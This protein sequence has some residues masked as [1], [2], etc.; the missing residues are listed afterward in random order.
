MT[1]EPVVPL[2]PQIS[3]EESFLSFLKSVNEARTL[4]DV[5][6]AA[7]AAYNDY[8]GIDLD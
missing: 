3:L 2:V 5:R 4:L 1:A 6:F 7:V 8:L